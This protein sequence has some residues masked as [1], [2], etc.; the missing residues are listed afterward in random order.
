MY[1]ITV[2]TAKYDTQLLVKKFGKQTK[3]L[4]KKARQL[5]I[6]K[7]GEKMARIFEPVKP[8]QISQLWTY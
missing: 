2:R 5:D 3:N 6:Q 1:K 7:L 4:R 8:L